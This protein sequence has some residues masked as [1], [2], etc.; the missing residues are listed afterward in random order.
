MQQRTKIVLKNTLEILESKLGK[1]INITMLALKSRVS[2]KVFNRALIANLLH[3]QG[4]K[5]AEIAEIFNNQRSNVTFY[6]SYS[7]VDTTYGK[8]SKAFKTI[9]NR[10]NEFNEILHDMKPYMPKL[11]LQSELE[12]YKELHYDCL[13][14]IEDIKTKIQLDEYN[15]TNY[16]MKL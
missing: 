4:I 11:K 12:Y 14:N 15:E 7:Q 6:L 5:S 10:I 8:H 9:Q 16:T 13:A 3:M 2:D 1:V